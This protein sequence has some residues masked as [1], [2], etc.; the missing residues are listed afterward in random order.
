[1]SSTIR[2]NSEAPPDQWLTMSNQGTDCFLELLLLAASALE[3]T[4]AQRSLI[5]FLAERREINRIAPGT[6]GF[7]VDEMPWEADSPGEDVSFLLR[8]VEGAKRRSGW[9]Q[10]DYAPREEIVFPWLERFA[11]MLGKHGEGP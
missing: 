3:Q 2:S 8:A 4:P 10:L 7:D 11:Q 6:A 1:M 9:E 5:A